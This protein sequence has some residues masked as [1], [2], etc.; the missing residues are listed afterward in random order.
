MEEKPIIFTLHARV[1]LEERGITEAEAIEVVRKG[2]SAGWRDG[3]Q[4]YEYKS[5]I[6]VLQD[7]SRYYPDNYYL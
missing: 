5:N 7:H 2:K 4:V 1:R 3:A 6:V